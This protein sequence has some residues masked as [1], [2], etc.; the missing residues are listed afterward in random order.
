MLQSVHR[1]HGRRWPTARS[2]LLA[3]ALLP[4]AVTAAPLLRCQIEQ[5]NKTFQL[6]FAPVDDP[7][8]V[9]AVDINGR[10][11]FKAVVIGDAT[12]VDYIKLYTY[13]QLRRQPMLMHEVKYLAPVAVPEP[14]PASLTGVHFV[15]SPRLERELQ[16]G[17]ALWEVAP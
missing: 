7:Y 11:S 8:R 15:Y 12:R 5:G 6:D 14:A 13:S 10:F 3:C 2:A 16:Y 17:C 9:K 4:L 1:H